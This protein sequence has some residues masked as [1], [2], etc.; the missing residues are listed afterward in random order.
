MNDYRII[1]AA[2]D[3]ERVDAFDRATTSVWPEFM[4]HDAISNRLSGRLDTDFPD[5]Q[6][7]VVDAGDRPVAH[8]N[9]APL[10][11][12]GDTADLPDDGWDWALETAFDGL[13]AGQTPTLVSA[14][15]IK[16]PLALRG[17]GYSAVAVQAM[18]EIAARHGF[19]TLIAPVRPSLKPRYPLI[20]IDRYARWQRPDGLPFDPWLRVHARAGAVIIRPCPLS[21]RI[22]GTVAEWEAWAGMAFPETGTY[23]VEGALEPV[24]IDRERGEGVYIEPN[25]W[26]Y[27]RLSPGEG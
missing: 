7:I 11:Y 9:S 23:T 10:R 25:V 24:E 27:H 13:S 2:D 21:M 22:T 5:Y 12:T 17:Q 18:R 4:L 1:T 6:F 20:D 26:V 3:P 15:S 14:L 8:G 16:V 19:D